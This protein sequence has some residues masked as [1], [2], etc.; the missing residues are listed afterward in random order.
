MAP[1]SDTLG[2]GMPSLALQRGGASFTGCQHG[3]V[4]TGHE[5]S[6]VGRA[7]CWAM[8]T[9]TELSRWLNESQDHR[10]HLQAFDWSCGSAFDGSCGSAFD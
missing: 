3:L 4:A 10:S 6:S 7:S 1:V 8:V 9:V 2:C 5:Q